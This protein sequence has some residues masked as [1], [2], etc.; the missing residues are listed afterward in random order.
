M[1]NVNKSITITGSSKVTHNDSEVIAVQLHANIS[2]QGNSNI[3]SV[4]VNK[5]AYEANKD[6]CRADIDEFTLM[7]REIEDAE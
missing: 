6:A 1:L 4:I 3:N 5:E 2:E 7:V